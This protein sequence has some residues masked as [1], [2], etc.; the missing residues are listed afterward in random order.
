MNER[1]AA[2]PVWFPLNLPAA[3]AKGIPAANLS[4]QRPEN[5]EQ[6]VVGIEPAA[7]FAISTLFAAR[8]ES[9]RSTYSRKFSRLSL[10]LT[11][12]M[13]FGPKVAL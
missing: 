11:T 13:R 5:G 4:H 1:D 8:F 10:V 12:V 9:D 6:A 2:K 3:P 7:T